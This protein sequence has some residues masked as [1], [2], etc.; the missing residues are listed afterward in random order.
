M[1]TL[2]ISE[3]GQ[4]QRAVDGYFGVL[5]AARISLCVRR[6]FRDYAA[7]RHANGDAHLNQAFDPV[8]TRF[9]ADDFWLLAQNRGRPDRHLLRA[10]VYCR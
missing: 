1:N 7:I 5:A 6:N 8:F 4:V 9:G 2:S 3:C 10:P